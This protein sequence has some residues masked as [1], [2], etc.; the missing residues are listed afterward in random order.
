MTYLS[1]VKQPQSLLG[2]GLRTFF[3]MSSEWALTEEQED[4][5]LGHPGHATLQAWR[6]GEYQ[7]ARASVLNHVSCLLGIYKALHTLFPDSGQANRWI[8]RQITSPP[9]NGQSALAVMCSGNL[10]DLMAVR[11]FLEG[12][13]HGP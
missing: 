9:F 3:N 10:D 8:K 12:E 1:S 2:P 6:Q 5:L 11:L 4:Q 13:L 7:D